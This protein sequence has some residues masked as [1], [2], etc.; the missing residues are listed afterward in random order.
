MPLP[1]PPPIEHVLSR[2]LSVP[3]TL[4]RVPG[5]P[6]DGVMIIPTLVLGIAYVV[7]PVSAATLPV[8]VIV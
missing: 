8:P 7:E 4:T 5:G 6:E 2:F 1:E 3:A